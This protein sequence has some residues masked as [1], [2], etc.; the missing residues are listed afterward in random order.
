MAKIWD[1]DK[2]DWVEFVLMPPGRIRV[3][4]PPEWELPDNS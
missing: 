4:P 2:R 1:K 3:L